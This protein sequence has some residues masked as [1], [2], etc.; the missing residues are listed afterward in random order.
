M[1]AS[2]LAHTLA[3]GKPVILA[4]GDTHR[5]RVDHPLLDSA[6]QKP[7]EH[8]TRIES[9]GS[10]SVDLIR[11]SVDPADPKLLLIKTGREINP[12]R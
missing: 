4:H 3:F 12:V 2:A 10:P 6:T 1:H 8:F 7:V 5:Y 11:A 9:F